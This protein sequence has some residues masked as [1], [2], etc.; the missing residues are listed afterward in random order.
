MILYL[1]ACTDCRDLVIDYI[2]V[3]LKSGKT[4]SLN[5][6]ESEYGQENGIFTARYKGVYFDEEYANGRIAELYGMEIDQIGVYTESKKDFHLTI[7]EMLFEDGENSYK[8][9]CLPYSTDSGR[10]DLT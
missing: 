6:D 9:D 7:K 1:E 3:R 10:C 4:V 5:W 2:E 8:P